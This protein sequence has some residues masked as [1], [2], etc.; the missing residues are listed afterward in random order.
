VPSTH[1]TADVVPQICAGMGIDLYWRNEPMQRRIFALA[2][3]ATA[4][5]KMWRREAEH[6]FVS[7]CT[8]VASEIGSPTRSD[9]ADVLASASLD[10]GAAGEVEVSSAVRPTWSA[11]THLLPAEREALITSCFSK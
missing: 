7:A 5:T 10:V 3:A 1:S 6:R 2:W 9:L 11:R 4:G 8:V